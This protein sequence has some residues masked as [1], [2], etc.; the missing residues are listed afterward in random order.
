MN[1]EENRLQTRLGSSDRATI[2]PS[3]TKLSGKNKKRGKKNKQKTKGKNSIRVVNG[4]VAIKVPGHKGVLKFSPS[5]L[6]QH[7]NKKN[8]RQ[9]AK[10]VLNKSQVGGGGG[11]PSRKRRRSK[12]SK[13]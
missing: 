10:T 5:H 13:S 2:V 9:A 1:W 7:V 6:I 11:G 4:R 12:K 3:M 8:L